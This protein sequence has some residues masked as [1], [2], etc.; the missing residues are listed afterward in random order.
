MII[1][2]NLT[3]NKEEEPI[4]RVVEA[5]GDEPVII[6]DI[7]IT[8]GFGLYLSNCALKGAVRAAGVPEKEIHFDS[9]K[10]YDELIQEVNDLVVSKANEV[11]KLRLNV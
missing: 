10:Q 3:M 1:Y 11:Y 9:F 2:L 8:T 5:N 7:D 4:L 6:R